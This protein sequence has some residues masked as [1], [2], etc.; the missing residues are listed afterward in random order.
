MRQQKE[1]KLWK[2]HMGART[3]AIPNHKCQLC[4]KI[5]EGQMGY[6]MPQDIPPQ[7]HNVGFWC[8][9]CFTLIQ[10]HANTG[11][12][13]SDTHDVE[14]GGES[15]P[16]CEEGCRRVFVKGRHSVRL[17]KVVGWRRVPK[18]TNHFPELHPG[19]WCPSHLLNTQCTKQCI[20]KLLEQV[21]LVCARMLHAKICWHFW[22]FFCVTRITRDLN[23][24]LFIV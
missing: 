5:L 9:T 23:Y 21:E 19:V 22:Y 4:G 7:T 16:C 13:P 8:D 14:F 12:K 10:V 17:L 3:P 6:L 1:Q 11:S 15:V 18:T 2:T 20:G 24:E